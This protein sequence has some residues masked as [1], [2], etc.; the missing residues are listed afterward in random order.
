MKIAQIA[1]LAERVPPKKYGGTERMVHALTEELV[2]RGHQV[3]LFASGD[4]ITSA[5]LVSVYPI[6]L[7]EA[8]VRDLYGTNIYTMLNI[9]VAYENQRKFDIIHDHTGT[10]GLPVANIAKT[11]SVFTLHGPITIEH[12]KIF[13]ALNK[14]HLITISKIQ[15][16]H[17]PNL[18]I[19]DTV[20][21]GLEMDDYPF[22]ALPK[23][24]LLY[25]GRLS[26]EKGVHYAIQAA[27]YLNMPLILAAKLESADQEYFN[28][29]IAP[30]LSSHIRWI[31]EVNEQ[32]RNTLMSQAL[33]FL[34]PVS[35]PEPF[36]LTMIEAM[37]CGC[38]VVAFNKGSIPEIIRHGKTGYVVNTIDEMI[39]A[40]LNIKNISRQYCRWY[41]LRNFNA[42]IMT[43][44]YEMA[45]K[46]VLGKT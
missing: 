32:K 29:F 46:K 36:G 44:R 39:D 14:P 34:H 30:Y 26:P 4:S 15:G 22:S 27:M 35:W 42:K 33:C 24:F 2:K 18:N 8:R 31:G 38:P 10:L 43:E 23:N 28:S 5:Q 16:A 25:V 12:K 17:A 1:P 41:A 21:N 6:G 19:L 11:P 45:Y 37:A 9:G 7:R 20:Y 13:Q 3:T 40:I